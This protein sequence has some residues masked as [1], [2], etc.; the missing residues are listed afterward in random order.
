[1]SDALDLDIIEA[2]ANAATKGPWRW[3]AN[4]KGYPQEIV[5]NDDGLILVAQTITGPE[6]F[7]SEAEFIAH[8]RT[9][10]PALVAALREAETT[11]TVIRGITTT[12]LDGVTDP[13][14]DGMALARIATILDDKGEPT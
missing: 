9:D 13:I 2:R 8:A 7:P 14:A 12:A 1:M 4:D 10:V 6:H 3:Q 5:G 11:L